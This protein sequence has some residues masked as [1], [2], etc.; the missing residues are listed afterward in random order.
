MKFFGVSEVTMDQKRRVL[1]KLSG[2][3]LSAPGKTLDY[4]KIDAV[5]AVLKEI[6]A[7]GVQQGIVVGGGNIMRG[8]A[9][10]DMDRT[11]A[12]HMGMLAT[13]INAIALKDALLRIGAKAAVMSAIEMKQ[14]CE[15]FTK[16]EAVER[17]DGGEI[18]IFA[19]GTGRPFFSTDTA[20]AL[21]ALEIGA[22]M[23]YCG[24]AVDGVYDK[25]PR[26]FKDARRYDE[27]SYDEVI[28]KRLEA[29][30][31]ASVILCRDRPGGGLPVFVFELSEPRNLID[32]IDGR[33]R[34]TFIR[35]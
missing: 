16:R 10:G 34:G 17:L 33:C 27:I 13:V 30:D 1:I 25:D 7:R 3:M 15:T 5:A 18:V 8:R 23:L 4:D 21:R 26:K 19:A 11:D 35:G 20:A 29:L 28:L 32:A 22:D 2:E 6:A 14:V 12:D 9:S 31:Q 24:K